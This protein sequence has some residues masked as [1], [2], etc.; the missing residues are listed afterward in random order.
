MAIR[1]HPGALALPDNRPISD[2]GSG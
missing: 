1:G 2:D